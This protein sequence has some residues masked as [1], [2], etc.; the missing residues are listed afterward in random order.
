AVR[1]GLLLYGIRPGTGDSGPGFSPALSLKTTVLRVKTV[2]AGA[3]VGY[4]ATF[5]T[6]RESRLATLA[7]GYDD[8]MPRTLAGNGEVL[9]GG[10]RAPLV[11]A[12]S[13]DL[14]VADVTDCGDVAPGT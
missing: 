1:P 12:V 6:A 9:V 14:S 5:R 11:G 2:P 13:M 3:P 8:G 7:I 4:S 10:R